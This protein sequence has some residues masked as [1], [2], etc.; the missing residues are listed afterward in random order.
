MPS[1]S[2]AS[3]RRSRGARSPGA[4]EGPYRDMV[5]ASPRMQRI[6]RLIEEKRI[7]GVLLI[8][9]DRH[10]ARGF[11]IPHP[12]GFEL[13]EFGAASLGRSPTALSTSPSRGKA[14]GGPTS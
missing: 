12:S 9:G 13:Y 3:P 2:T 7:P 6:F 5:G 4:L 14:A 1:A 10:G 11:R 8:S